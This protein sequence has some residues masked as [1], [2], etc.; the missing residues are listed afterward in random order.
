DLIALLQAFNATPGWTRTT[1][2]TLL[3]CKGLSDFVAGI[4]NLF[5]GTEP[6]NYELNI[7]EL[8]AGRHDFPGFVIE[9]A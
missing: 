7:V 5:D 3:G 6:E 9:T 8:T 2:L 4:M 1:P